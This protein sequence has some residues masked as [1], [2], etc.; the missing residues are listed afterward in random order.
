MAEAFRVTDAHGRVYRIYADWRTDGFYGPVT[1]CNF[2]PMLIRRSYSSA[3]EASPLATKT[4]TAD[5]NGVPH[6]RAPRAV[7]TVENSLAAIG[8]K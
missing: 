3:S 6:G 7:K 8:E 4:E 1:L 2:I 5:R